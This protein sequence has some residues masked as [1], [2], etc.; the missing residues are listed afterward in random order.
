LPVHDEAVTLFNRKTCTV[1]FRRYIGNN[2]VTVN[3]CYYFDFL[4]VFSKHFQV[5]PRAFCSLYI[6]PKISGRR[7]CVGLRIGYI[8]DLPV[9]LV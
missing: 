4:Y 3:S 7:S 6:V 5:N 9:A 8:I 1:A 2:Y